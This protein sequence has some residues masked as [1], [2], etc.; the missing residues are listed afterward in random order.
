M[1]RRG[2]DKTYRI[3]FDTENRHYFIQKKWLITYHFTEYW[4]VD[5]AGAKNR[6]KILRE[7]HKKRKTKVRRYE[8][9]DA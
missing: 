1:S 3:V 2:V 5:L 6:L 9:I 8:V 4:Y 7:Q